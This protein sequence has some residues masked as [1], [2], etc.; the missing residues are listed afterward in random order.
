M[1]EARSPVAGSGARAPAAGFGWQGPVGLRKGI[2]VAGR[3]SGSDVQV[4]S[5]CR[6]L[7]PR[8]EIRGGVLELEGVDV[9]ERVFYEV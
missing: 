7:A 1:E 9:G 4:G 2:G 3:G 8:Q 5:G 6:L